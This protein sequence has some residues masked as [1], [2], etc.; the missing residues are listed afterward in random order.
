[1][2]VGDRVRV[3]ALRAGRRSQVYAGMEGTIAAGPY[4][5]GTESSFDVTFEAL[6]GRTIGMWR[7]EL[8]LAAEDEW[9]FPYERD[10]F[11]HAFQHGERVYWSGEGEGYVD[12]SVTLRN[13]NRVRRTSVPIRF[14]NGYASGISYESVVARCPRH[15]SRR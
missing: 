4:G 8:R 3:H 14:D 9:P 11:R 10:Y 2:N 5:V 1:M 15:R 13:G 6:G 12:F 7:N